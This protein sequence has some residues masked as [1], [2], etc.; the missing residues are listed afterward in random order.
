MRQGGRKVA[1]AQR[2]RGGRRWSGG[3]AEMGNDGA[4]EGTRTTQNGGEEDDAALD[5]GLCRKKHE[6]F[7]AKLPSRHPFMDGG[8]TYL[9]YFLSGDLF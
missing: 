9:E 6:G 5:R 1:G 2:G 8:S 7:S 3:G 4:L